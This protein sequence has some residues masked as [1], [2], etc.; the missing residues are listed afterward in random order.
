MIDGLN[1]DTSFVYLFSCNCECGFGSRRSLS[2]EH[3][4]FDTTPLRGLLPKT[5]Y[6]HINPPKFIVGNEGNATEMAYMFPFVKA[7]RKQCHQ[8]PIPPS[9]DVQD[10]AREHEAHALAPGPLLQSKI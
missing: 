1:F 6:E 4:V 3:L 5:F 10:E 2:R 7:R 9:C 8:N